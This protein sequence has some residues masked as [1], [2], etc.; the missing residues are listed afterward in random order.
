MNRNIYIGLVVV[1]IVMVFAYFYIGRP[2][3][4]PAQPAATE[5]VEVAGSE[6]PLPTPKPRARLPPRRCRLRNLPRLKMQ[7]LLQPKSAPKQSWNS[8]TPITSPSASRSTNRLPRALWPRIPAS[9]C[10]SSPLMNLVSLKPWPTAQDENRLPDIAR[11]GIERVAT[12]A[13]E[14]L[15]DEAAAQAVIERIGVDDFRAGP[16]KIVTNPESGMPLAVPYDGWIQAI[17]YRRDLFAELGLEAPVTWAQLDA[18]CDALAAGEQPQ[19]ALTLGT[20]PEQNYVHQLFEQVAMSNNAWPFDEAGNVTMNS[21][22]MVE[23]LRF[24]TDLQRCAPPGPQDLYGARERYEL[25]Q[26]GFLFYSTYIMDDLVEGSDLRD[27]SG[28]VPI[29]VEELAGKTSFASS[30][31]GPGGVAS[32]GQLATLGITKDADPAAQ[33]VVEYFLTEGYLDVLALAPLGKVPVL[34]SAVEKWSKLSPI[35]GYYSPATLGHIA[36]SY[37]AMQRWLFR[38]A[39]Y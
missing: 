32:Y 30:L 25:D 12:L 8:G 7:R 22:Q 34:E 2:P 6:S 9:R 14:G 19:Y 17:W 16:L 29:A 28:K 27:G 24:Y 15:L 39:I 26:T 21:P 5:P 10:V 11:L 1:L 35:F 20:T 4:A 31:V 3:T 13:A 38:A 33:D 36:N 18:A 23:A 37:D